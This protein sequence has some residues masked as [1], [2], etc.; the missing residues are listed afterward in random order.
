MAVGLHSVFLNFEGRIALNPSIRFG[1][2]GMVFL[3]VL[4]PL[5]SRAVEK[6][7]EKK[8]AVISGLLALILAADCICTFVLKLH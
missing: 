4:Q 5:F 7:G 8:V 3:Y 1:I 6:L 2:G